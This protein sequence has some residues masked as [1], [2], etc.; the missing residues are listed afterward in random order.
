[1][2]FVLCTVQMVCLVSLSILAMRTK[3]LAEDR[4]DAIEMYKEW[5][6][7]NWHSHQRVVGKLE[8]EIAKLKGLNNEEV[9]YD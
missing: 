6:D 1:M 3:R 4:Q 5:K 9:R 7:I 2:I 8:E